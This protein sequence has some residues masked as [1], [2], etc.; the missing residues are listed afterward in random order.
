MPLAQVGI[1]LVEVLV[2]LADERKRQLELVRS[3]SP[4]QLRAIRELQR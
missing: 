3:L 1:A 2:K 4:E